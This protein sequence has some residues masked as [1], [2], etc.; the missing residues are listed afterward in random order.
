M[1][2]SSMHEATVMADSRVET[3]NQVIDNEV[4]KEKLQLRAAKEWISY[5]ENENAEL[6]RQLKELQEYKK[7]NESQIEKRGNN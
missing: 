7:Q 1:I 5:L 3:E 4:G 2:M 6:R